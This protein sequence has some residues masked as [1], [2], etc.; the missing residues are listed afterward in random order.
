MLSI[1]VIVTFFVNYFFVILLL[2]FCCLKYIIIIYYQNIF[3]SNV[4]LSKTTFR[5]KSS[6]VLFLVYILLYCLYI[7]YFQLRLISFENLFLNIPHFHKFSP[8]FLIF[9]LIFIQ[10]QKVSKHPLDAQSCMQ[11]DWQKK[12]THVA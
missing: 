3:S 11:T 9:F 7:L 1:S 6:T 10:I 4:I 12:F 8:E 2:N 5:G